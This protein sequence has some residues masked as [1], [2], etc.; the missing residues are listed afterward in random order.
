MHQHDFRKKKNIQ[1]NSGVIHLIFERW[2][3]TSRLVGQGVLEGRVA[4]PLFKKGRGAQL[5]RITRPSLGI[6]SL[7]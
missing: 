5:F 1:R 6:L 7:P 4:L 3:P 2:Y